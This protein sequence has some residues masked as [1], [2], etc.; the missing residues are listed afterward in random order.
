MLFKKLLYLSAIFFLFNHF[1]FSQGEKKIIQMSGVVVGADSISGV[2]GVHIYVPK[3][4]RGTTSNPYGYFT[5]P[6]LEEDSLIIKGKG[7]IEITTK[8]SKIDPESLKE[9]EENIYAMKINCLTN[10]F[11]DI[12]VNG[13]K[14]LSAKWEDPNGDKLLDDAISDSCENV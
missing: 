2:G 11:K 8:Y 10:E 12:S 9:I 6:V 4:G 14:N 3:A 1:T 7:I 13:K 5:M